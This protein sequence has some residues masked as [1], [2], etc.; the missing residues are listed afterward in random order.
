[1]YNY[2]CSKGLEKDVAY[3]ITTFVGKGKVCTA[4]YLSESNVNKGC[5]QKWNEYKEIMKKHDIPEWY[6]KSAEK[7][8]YMFPKS[9]SIS[10]T[11]LA[12]KIAWHK[13]KTV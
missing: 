6:I 1:M 3:N 13:I 2:L 5:D 10:Y 12:F 4:R 11:M 9:H 8:N 7:I